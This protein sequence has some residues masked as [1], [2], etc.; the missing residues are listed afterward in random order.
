MKFILT[1]IKAVLNI[2]YAAVKCF[3]KQNK[4][5]IVS[6]QGNTPS[7][8]ISMLRDEIKRQSPD[9]EVLCLCRKIGPGIGGRISYA[10]H[11]LKQMWHLGTSRAIVT[12]SYC[13]GISLVKQRK[14]VKIVQMWHALGAFKKFGLSIAG[15]GGEGRSNVI[16]DAMNM[17]KNYTHIV[18]SGEKCREPYKEA[19]GYTNKELVKLSLP[20]VDSILDPEAEKTALLKI[21]K[22]YPELEG[23]KVVVYAPTFRKGRDISPEIRVLGK[24]LTEKEYVFVVKKHPLME[25]KGDFE[26]IIVDNIFTTL[27]ML[28]RADYVICDYSAVVFEAALMEKPL[29]FYNF[30]F[31]EYEDRRNFYLDYENDMP[32]V[33]SGD[34][35]RIASAIENDEFDM[36]RIKYFADS[37]IEN[38]S[39]CTVSLAEFVLE[40]LVQQ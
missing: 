10:F 35:E 27:E 12:D 30:D 40:P 29:F 38:R 5:T 17:H 19:F 22:E 3:P 6:R 24:K 25:L 21:H 11:L 16:A 13:I 31:E 34:P 14:D 23:R 15:E 9:T 1:L 33:I 7:A 8:D 26:N 18:I 32:G 37:Y 39:N 36:S 20:R 2:Y 4:V 28:Y